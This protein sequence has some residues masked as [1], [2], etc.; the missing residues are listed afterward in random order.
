[1]T[2][3][4]SSFLSIVGCPNVGK[5]SLMNSLVGQKI[6]IVT[7]RAQTTR[8][9]I[10]GVLT[11]D[12]YQI[13][14]LDTPGIMPPRNR[15]GEVMCK[16]TFDALRDV[17][18][19]LFVCDALAGLGEHDR[20]LIERLS[21]CTSP[22]LALINKCD[23]GHPMRM[24]QMEKTLIDTGLFDSINCISATTGENLKEL[25][26]LICRYLVEG[27]QYFPADMITDQPER[28]ICCEFIREKALLLLR[29]EIPHGVGVG[30]DKMERREDR[31]L[32][33]IFVTIYCERSSHKPIVVGHNGEMLKKIGIMARADIEWLLGLPVNLQLWVKISENWRNRASVLRE[34]GYE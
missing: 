17:E 8:N 15:L 20:M 2:A 19:I 34:L 31:D 22:R 26:S 30:V 6:S 13:I 12:T 27:P 11:R 7:D 10:T 25:E 24:E 3:H 18:A 1:M 21:Q 32:I 5:S 14:F 33:D 4:R 29:D 16:T 9:R 23:A 28:V